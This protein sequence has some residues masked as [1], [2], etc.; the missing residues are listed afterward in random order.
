MKR[1][2]FAISLA[3]ALAGPAFTQANPVIVPLVNGHTLKITNLMKPEYWTL[4]DNAGLAKALDQ[5]SSDYG[6]STDFN[7]GLNPSPGNLYLSVQ[8]I[9]FDPANSPKI[10][11]YAEGKAAYLPLGLQKAVMLAVADWA[12]FI[13]RNDAA[14][15]DIRGVFNQFIL[16]TP[17]RFICSITSKRRSIVVSGKLE[18]LRMISFDPKIQYRDMNIANLYSANIVIPA[19]YNDYA[20]TTVQGIM[21]LENPDDPSNPSIKKDTIWIYKLFGLR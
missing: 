8:S 1:I 12:L 7:V 14:P 9:E 19:P 10:A 15:A 20:F 5:I 6:L 3:L 4:F 17:P 13:I 2:V 11:A 16:T 21:Y 18:A